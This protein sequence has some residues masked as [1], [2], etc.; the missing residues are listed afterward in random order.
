L[1]VREI[2]TTQLTAPSLSL[3]LPE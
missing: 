3:S 2:E 1:R